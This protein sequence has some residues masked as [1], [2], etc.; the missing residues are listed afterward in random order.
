MSAFSTEMAATAADAYCAGLW[1]SSYA[2]KRRTIRGTSALLRRMRADPR[3]R[4]VP[5][6][7]VTSRTDAEAAALEAGADRHVV[8]R[9]FDQ[10]T[11]LDHVA[12]L[13]A[14]PRRAP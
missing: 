3:F 4:G 10:E 7:M 8:K 11:L 2:Q 14:A 1:E 6:I 5:A 9:A 13:L 12:E